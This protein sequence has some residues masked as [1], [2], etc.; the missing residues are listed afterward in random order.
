MQIRNLA[1]LLLLIA[2]A[3]AAHAEDQTASPQAAEPQWNEF[4]APERGFA[5]SFPGQPKPIAEPVAG[6]N[7]LIQYEYEVGV[8]D[9][10]VYDAVVFEYPQGKAPDPNPDYYLKLV[11]A[12]AKGSE[13]RLRKKGP[14]TIAGHEG[15]EATADDNKGKLNHLIDIVPAGD[16]IYML[17][18]AGPKGHAASD[19]AAK[20]RDSFRLISDQPA[21][22]QATP[23]QSSSGEPTAPP[24]TPPGPSAPAPATP[25]PP[26]P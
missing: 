17:V 9:D 12:Y 24:Q 7:P 22:A 15:F 26:T 19:D 8:G 16:R 3:S 13:S 14:A 4:Q 21:P 1:V 25:A 20:F 10:T 6:Q 23:G 18:S 2:S 11:S 5:I